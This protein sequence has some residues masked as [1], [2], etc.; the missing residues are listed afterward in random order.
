[1]SNFLGRFTR[2]RASTTFA[3]LISVVLITSSCGTN[4]EYALFVRSE[5]G[6]WGA[7]C[8]GKLPTITRAYDNLVVMKT[9]EPL[10]TNNFDAIL[11]SRVFYRNYEDEFDMLFVI[12]NLSREEFLRKDVSYWGKSAVVSNYSYGIGKKR[13]AY[14]SHYGSNYRLKAVIQ[15]SARETLLRGPSLHEIMHTWAM[16][17]VVPTT[18]SGHWG[19]SSAHG[20]LGG[21]DLE[22]LKDLGDGYYS[23]G[24]FG[25]NANFGNTLVY[26]PFELYLAGWLPSSEVPDVVVATNASWVT[27]NG[28]IRTDEEGNWIFRADGLETWSIEQIVEKLGKRIPSHERARKQFQAAVI[29]LEDEE[30]P[31]SEKDIQNVV[32]QIN[33]FTTHRDL[34]DDN[35]TTRLIN[36]WTATGGRATITMNGLDDYRIADQVEGDSVSETSD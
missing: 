2:L 14:G 19:F 33:L 16:N 15:L 11:A 36:F 26:S 3:A 9:R 17:G 31:A 28:E 20:Q 6:C 7:D 30:H 32:N 35:T 5:A 29:L 25:L 8:E 4:V 24:H 34:R 21:F 27:E 10:F 1:M 22:Q 23:A 12:Q 18:Y 13:F